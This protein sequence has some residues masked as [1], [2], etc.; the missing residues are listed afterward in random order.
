MSQQ[1][2]ISERI[3]NRKVNRTSAQQKEWEKCKKDPIYFINTYCYI[4]HP[5]KGTIKFKLWDFQ[6][7]LIK[8]FLDPEYRLT[9]II[10]SRQLGVSTL[11]SAIT[12]WL[13]NFFDAKTVGVVATDLRTAQE[14]HGKTIMMY[15]LLPDWLR[16]QFKKNNT[17]ELSLRNGSNVK[18]YAHNKKKGVRSLAATVVLMDEAA[19]IE[20]CEALFTTIQ[21]SLRNG[22]KLIALSSPSVPSGWFYET[23][24]NA[25]NGENGF[26]PI[27]LPWYLHPDAQ[28][29]DGS[30]DYNW[31]DEQDKIMGKRNA[32][33]EYDAE[34][35]VDGES[36][37][38][39]EFIERMEDLFISEPIRKEGKLWIWED[40]KDD[41]EYYSIVDVAE[42]GG[43]NNVVQVIKLSTL[44]QVAEYVDNEHYTE[45]QY[46]P[47]TIAKRYNMSKLIIEANSVGTSVV[48]KSVELEYPDVY[49]R[50]TGKEKKILGITKPDWG[51]KTTIKTRPLAVETL[52]SFVETT[53]GGI[54]IRSK[55]TLK[56]LKAFI[57]KNGKPQA[58]SGAHDDTI[59]PLAIGSFL[60]TIHGA[61]VNAT[62]NKSIEELLQTYSQANRRTKLNYAR[63]QKA[64]GIQTDEEEKESDD[65]IRLELM[66][67][68]AKILEVL[69]PKFQKQLYKE[70]NWVL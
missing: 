8:V 50:G 26:K 34:F 36:Y 9:T 32:R 21:P 61:T 7:E 60:Y 11:Y 67:E 70:F 40:P 58:R 31:R 65:I 25:E 47:V 57:S 24:T 44:E 43:D 63:Q 55:R 48:A 22:G 41:E 45:F 69:A 3:S 30:P 54:I 10:K 68:E 28:L 4:S 64:M 51:W 18:A 53:D 37:F 16:T 52:R 49:M 19:F 62:G 66:E 35:G 46:K 5:F 42:G 20:K 6:K 33:Q 29:P 14:L 38:D 15:E 56:E 59:M 1:P 27:K 17:K 2:K 39:P 23:H 12:L 13:I